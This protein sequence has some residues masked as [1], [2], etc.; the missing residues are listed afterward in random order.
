MKWWHFAANQN[1]P[2]AQLSIGVKFARGEGVPK[3]LVQAHMWFRLAARFDPER[4]IEY[5]RR[6]AGK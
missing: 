4:G 1:H 3:D 5:R 6:A 2:S